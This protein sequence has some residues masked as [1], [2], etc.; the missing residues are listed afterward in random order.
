M[1]Q[2]KKILPHLP[3]SNIN[4]RHKRDGIRLMM[5]VVLGCIAMAMVDLYITTYV[6]KSIYKIILFIGL[7][8]TYFL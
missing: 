7:P 8:I 3:A 1:K 5:L 4:E 6:F 2:T